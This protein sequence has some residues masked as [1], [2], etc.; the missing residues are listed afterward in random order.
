MRGVA[1]LAPAKNAGIAA[2]DRRYAMPV[3]SR[4]QHAP[5]PFLPLIPYTQ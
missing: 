5:N 2:L 1:V 4:G 3:M